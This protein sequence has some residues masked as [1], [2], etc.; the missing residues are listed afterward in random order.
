MPIYDLTCKNNH[1]R[2]DLLLKID[3]RPLC[4]EC[5]EITEMFWDG[6]SGGVIDD[7]IPGG[8]WIRH[9]ICDEITGEPRKYYSKS[10]IARE[11]ERRGLVSYVEH[12]PL[13]GSDKAK[14]TVRWTGTPLPEDIRLKEWWEHER[15][16]VAEAA[17]TQENT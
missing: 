14:H 9:G 4:P 8:V 17:K 16:L 7:S 3:E 1:I 2:R 12:I 5:G 11:A 15:R 6:S 10:E 13:P